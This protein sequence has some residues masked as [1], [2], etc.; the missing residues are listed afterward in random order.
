MITNYKKYSLIKVKHTTFI[1]KLKHFF[2]EIANAAAW[3]LRH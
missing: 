1:N 2:K 3:A